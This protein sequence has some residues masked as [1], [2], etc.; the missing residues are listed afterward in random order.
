VKRGHYTGRDFRRAITIE[1]LRRIARRRLPNFNFEY[2]EGGAEDESTLR[3]NR[4]VF[5]KVAWLPRALVG[6]GPPDLGTEI[7]GRAAHMPI[8]IAP[9]GFNGLLWPQGDIALARAASD[10]GIPFTLSTA[11]N[12]AVGR[13]AASVQGN[14]WYQLYAYKD[15]SVVDRLIDR[16]AEAG[17]EVLVITADAPVLGAREWDQRNYRAPMKLSLA[18]KLDVLR[19]PRWLAQVMLPSGAPTFEN[20]AEFLPPGKYSA[21]IGAKYSFSQINSR[22]SWHDVERIRAR[23]SGKLVVKG[24]LCVEDARRAVEAGADGIVL[25]NHGGRQLDGAVSGVEL[26]PAVA[27]EVGERL[28]VMV[29]GGFRRGGDVLK[30]IALGARAVLIGRAALYGLAAGGQAGASHALGMLR[31]EMDRTMM[32]LGCGSV[33]ELGRHLIRS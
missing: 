15:Q 19:H 32:L 5:E 23:W 10:A 2:V 11:S 3:R 8:V 1:D 29:D 17:C 13:L 22:L 4:E 12:C 33:A 26:L 7:F 24:L 31:A 9:T 30:A 28:T 27:S 6:A 14:L 25:S 16:V 18:S 20:L 21:L